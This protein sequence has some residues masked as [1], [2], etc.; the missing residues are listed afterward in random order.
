[1]AQNTPD[2]P[3]M[4]KDLARSVRASESYLARVMLWLTKAGLL[5]S[6]RGKKG[7]FVFK[8]PPNQITI[9][10]VVMA[11]DSDAAQYSCPWEERGCQLHAGC[12]LVNLFQEAQREMLRVLGRLTIADVAAAHE[13]ECGTSEWLDPTQTLKVLPSCS[14]S[15]GSAVV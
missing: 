5:R 1:M 15:S 7:G 12:T 11:I 14:Q 13:R 6:I 9:A 10:D 2:Q 3:V 4:I 8:I